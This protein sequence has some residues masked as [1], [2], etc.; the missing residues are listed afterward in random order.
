[1]I[2]P[3]PIPSELSLNTGGSRWTKDLPRN[4]VNSFTNRSRV[5]EQKREI[6]AFKEGNWAQNCGHW[7]RSWA[8]F[9]GVVG[10]VPWGEDAASIP[11]Q[12][13]L[14]FR[15]NTSPDR[16]TIELW[17]R[18]KE[19]QSWHDRA[20]IAPRSG[21]NRATIVVLRGVSSAVRWRSDRDEN[22]TRQIVPRGFT[23]CG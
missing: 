11:Q 5:E 18:R 15:F 10:A 3:A 4:L 13:W 20:L 12:D 21:Y 2:N 7:K 23:G 19:V 16:G 1:M 14:Q 8:L 9:E 17:S 22:P 6:H